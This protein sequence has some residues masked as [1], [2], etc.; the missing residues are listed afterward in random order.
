MENMSNQL[1]GYIALAI[2]IIIGW[3]LKGL[4]KSIRE[5]RR[6]VSGI[7][8]RIVKNAKPTFKELA[9]AIKRS[10]VEPIDAECENRKFRIVEK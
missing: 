6:K 9:D 2:G 4:W 8:F 5:R 7:M 1:I 3:A 10:K